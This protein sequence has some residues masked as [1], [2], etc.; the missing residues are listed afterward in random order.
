VN[1]GRVIEL[2]IDI[3]L[4]QNAAHNADLVISVHD[5]KVGIEGEARSL[6]A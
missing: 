5:D 6:A 1:A 2:F 3:E 4:L